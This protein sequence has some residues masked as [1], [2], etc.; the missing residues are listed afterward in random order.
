[1]RIIPLEEITQIIANP[2]AIKAVHNGFIAFSNGQITQ[3]DPMQILF[4]E[5]DGTFYGDCH[6]KAAQGKGQPFFV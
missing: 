1:M 2:E 3:P 6:A 5:D 4:T